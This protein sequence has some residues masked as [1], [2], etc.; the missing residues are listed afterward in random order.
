MAQSGEQQGQRRRKRSEAAKRLSSSVVKGMANPLR[1]QV[2]TI[3][4]ERT[5]SATEISREVGAPREKVIYEMKVLADAKLI[6]EIAQKPARGALEHFYRGTARAMVDDTVW[7]EVP[8]AAKCDLRATL[9]R[10]LTEDAI[11]AIAEEA[12]DSRDDSHMSWTPLIVDEQ[13]CAELAA[14]L[15]RA[16][17]EV[18][19]VQAS[20]AERL[21]AIDAEGISYTVS[22][23]GYT[24]AHARR[25][26][27]PPVDAGQFVS[28]LSDLR[29]REKEE[30]TKEQ[31]AADSQSD[32]GPSEPGDDRLAD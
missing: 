24:S 1:I 22:I 23:L 12:Y 5:A 26:V 25:K 29:I 2:W 16:L 14:I 7:P 19:G 32:D 15:V 18:L 11:E 20:S 28:Q 10:T 27:G 4:N 3:L 13:G 6:E 9:L 8:N 31:A 17:D 21:M 30:K